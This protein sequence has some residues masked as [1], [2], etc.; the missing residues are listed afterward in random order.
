[1]ASLSIIVSMPFVNLNFDS[2]FAVRRGDFVIDFIRGSRPQYDWGYLEYADPSYLKNIA[3]SLG[4]QVKELEY[5]EAITESDLA[6]ASVLVEFVPQNPYF[7]DEEINL[8][9]RFVENGGGLYIV[10]Y[11]EY[12]SAYSGWHNE[13]PNPYYNLLYELFGFKITG[14][15]TYLGSSQ[16]IINVSS[17]HPIFEGVEIIQVFRR[18]LCQLSYVQPPSFPLLTIDGKTL[19]LAGSYGNG[20][21]FVDL[22]NMGIGYL[23]KYDNQILVRNAIIWVS[24]NSPNL[25]QFD[26]RL[27]VDPSFGFVEAGRTVSIN[28]TVELVSGFPQPVT[29]DV[30]ELPSGVSCSFKPNSQN[31]PFISKLSITTSL[32]TPTGGYNITICGQGGEITR[33]INVTLI[34]FPPQKRFLMIRNPAVSPDNKV[35]YFELQWHFLVLPYEET[36]Y[37]PFKD[38]NMTVEA[39]P[40]TRLQIFEPV[41]ALSTWDQ[42]S[43]EIGGAIFD[44]AG[45]MLDS[46]APIPISTVLDLAKHAE[47]IAEAFQNARERSISAFQEYMGSAGFFTELVYVVQIKSDI[48]RDIWPIRLKASAIHMIGPNKPGE[49]I[50]QNEVAVI[51][52]AGISQ[53]EG[54]FSMEICANVDVV[55]K[56]YTLFILSNSTIS[57]LN[58]SQ[59]QKKLSFNVEG[60]LGTEG[61]CNVTIP[62]ELLNA[63][64]TE[65]I[66]LVD[67]ANPKHLVITWNTTQTFIY[68]TYAHS[69]HLVEIKGTYVVPEYNI[70]TAI[71]T[72]MTLTTLIITIKKR[73][74]RTTK[75][76]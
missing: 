17:E 9:L 10:P 58:F 63:N 55:G 73:E 19:F 64:H 69:V 38:V 74:R 22:T 27:M 72:L 2:A 13:Y 24:A 42:I 54:I 71:L 41:P 50:T 70:I 62:K 14:E 53:T 23:K 66:V 20:R 12:Y 40:G 25:A 35:L 61:F 36:T 44:A 51:T 49:T 21:I 30:L 76:K 16:E 57:D 33:Y 31:P 39:P 11:Y 32:N 52:S 5:K 1:M 8:I 68:L 60:P 56:K 34:V 65:W 45:I 26:Y 48:A 15:V 46:I 3:D 18:G 47:K 37:A 43:T 28:V 6:N 75:R 59:E 67:G 4:F 7:S 29:L